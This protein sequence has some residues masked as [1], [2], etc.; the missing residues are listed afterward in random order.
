VQRPA[1]QYEHSIDQERYRYPEFVR[2]NLPNLT[3]V[4]PENTVWNDSRARLIPNDGIE[5]ELGK[6]SHARHVAISFDG[7]DKYQ[8]LF[9]HGTRGPAVI[10]PAEHGGLMRTRSLDTPDEAVREGFDQL[11]IRPLRGD[12]MYSLGY[13]RRSP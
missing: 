6:V 2:E 7:K 4:I 1:G 10:S 13:V 3:A 8:V 5:I 9:K 12:G 11:V